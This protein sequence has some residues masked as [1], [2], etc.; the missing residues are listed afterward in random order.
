MGTK[1]G[2]PEGKKQLGR[3]KL[4]WENNIKMGLRKI[5]LNSVDWINLAQ[6]MQAYLQ[7]DLESTVMDLRVP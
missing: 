3:I 2:R 4:K 6:D 1:A 7:R 5:W